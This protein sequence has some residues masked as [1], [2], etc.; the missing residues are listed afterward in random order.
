MN[1]G[2]NRG[3]PKTWC[4]RKLPFLD[5]EKCERFMAFEANGEHASGD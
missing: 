2:R 4:M 1:S 5:R 3:R